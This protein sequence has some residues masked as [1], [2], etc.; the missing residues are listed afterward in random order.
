MLILR[1]EDLFEKPRETYART[2]KFLDLDFFD[3][4]PMR[5]YNTGS[6][7]SVDPAIIRYLSAIYAEP[8]RRLQGLLGADFGWSHDRPSQD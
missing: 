7:G 2:L 6:Y 5:A 1:S 4:G 8:N 3:L